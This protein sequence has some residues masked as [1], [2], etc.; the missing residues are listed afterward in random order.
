MSNIG[1]KIRNPQNNKVIFDTTHGIT[2][3]LGVYRPEDLRQYEN[4]SSDSKKG[5]IPLDPTLFEHGGQVFAW[6][7]NPFERN[8]SFG[9]SDSLSMY[10]Y[11]ENNTFYYRKN[12]HQDILNLGVFYGRRS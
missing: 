3:L 5:Q 8:G 1:I 2:R 6:W 4:D 9:N 12:H 10:F 7:T 11:I